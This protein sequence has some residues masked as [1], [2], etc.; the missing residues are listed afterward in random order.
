MT[1]DDTTK[2]FRRSRPSTDESTTAPILN[3]SSED[4]MQHVSGTEDR[5]KIFRPTSHSKSGSSGEEALGNSAFSTDPVAGWVVVVR[6]PGRGSSHTI[7]YGMNAIGRG[8][9]NRVNLDFEDNEISRENHAYLTYDGKNKKFYIH[10]GGGTNLTYVNGSPVL[11]PIE[12]H[13]RELIQI[14]ETS[15]VFIPFCGDCFNWEA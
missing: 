7:G 10:H 14:G 5:T 1:S 3:R 2:V 13:G 15:C 11:S 8:S 9:A 4:P 12:L 6:G